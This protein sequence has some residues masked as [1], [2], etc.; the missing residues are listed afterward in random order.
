MLWV[1]NSTVVFIVLQIRQQFILQHFAGLHVDRGERLV[2]Q[3]NV[4]LLRERARQ[5]D[6]LLHAAGDLMRVVVSNPVS[7]TRLI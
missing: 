1:T 5:R 6:A 3:Q 2:H 7:P 4:R